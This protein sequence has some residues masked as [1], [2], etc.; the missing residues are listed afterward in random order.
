[1]EP[2]KTWFSSSRIFWNSTV[3][4]SVSHRRIRCHIIT[5]LPKQKTPLSHAVPSLLTCR[6]CG[7]ID[8]V[9][10]LKVCGNLVDINRKLICTTVIGKL[11]KELS[12]NIGISIAKLWAFL[13]NHHRIFNTMILL[14]FESLWNCFLFLFIYIVLKTCG[15]L[16]T[17]VYGFIIKY[18]LLINYVYAWHSVGY[19]EEK[20]D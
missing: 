5:R 7:I 6:H 10:R 4:F 9:L 3:I 14:F 12:K 1:M 8:V 2:D 13:K 16:Y 19:V 18:L 17:F 11:Y 15:R 20:S